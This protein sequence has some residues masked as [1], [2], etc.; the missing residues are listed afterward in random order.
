MKIDFVG[1]IE[2]LPIQTTSEKSLFETKYFY[3]PMK[4]L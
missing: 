1:S 2:K 3:F 4:L